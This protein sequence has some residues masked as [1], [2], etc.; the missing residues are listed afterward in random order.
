MLDE[1]DASSELEALRLSCISLV[2]ELK[3]HY[4]ETGKRDERLNRDWGESKE[5]LE[6]KKWTMEEQVKI[7]EK[8]ILATHK[9]I[10][11]IKPRRKTRY[12]HVR[13]VYKQVLSEF[14]F[15]HNPEKI[16][17][18]DE[19][20]DHFHGRENE[21]MATI[22]QRYDVEVSPESFSVHGVTLTEN[23]RDSVLEGL[24]ME[25]EKLWDQVAELED[26]VLRSTYELEKLKGELYFPQVDGWSFKQGFDG[27]Y[28]ACNDF[29][30]EDISAKISLSVHDR[31][32]E[33]RFTVSVGGTEKVAKSTTGTVNFDQDES[34]PKSALPSGGAKK[35][36]VVSFRLDKFGLY[37]E[38]G[39]KVPT[40][41]MTQIVVLVE[42][43]LVVPVYFKKKIGWRASK[44]FEFR[45]L[46]VER[47]ITGSSIYVPKSLLKLVLNQ[48]LPGVIRT[49]IMKIIPVELGT[50]LSQRYET[51]SKERQGA[52][53]AMHLDVDLVITG[54]SMDLATLDVDIST[55][56]PDNGTD[57][58]A[59]DAGNARQFL[60]LSH[61]QAKTFVR[62]QKEMHDLYLKY[63]PYV[64]EKDKKLWPSKPL[65]NASALV[66]Y[67]RR[68][69]MTRRGAIITDEVSQQN[70]EISRGDRKGSS[71]F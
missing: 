8:E 66:E 17:N 16:K 71:F 61:E 28:I 15:V 43:Q 44:E 22:K 54:G 49:A 21:M 68:H 53:E 5:L 52:S 25:A 33:P 24:D 37:G 18:L 55:P 70:T 6:H 1:S 46:K 23:A 9:K 26:L 38:A 42:F 51:F 11:E 64:S 58:A 59:N 3:K 31:S 56:P 34:S 35:G 13:K 32:N 39:T 62:A 63:D 65:T 27:V 19:V 12:A 57:K 29:W 4:A 41:N 67:Y 45:I 60:Q 36:G 30:L 7:L 20:L 10:D 69:A 50:Y 40:L 2:N 47:K 48:I 14:Y